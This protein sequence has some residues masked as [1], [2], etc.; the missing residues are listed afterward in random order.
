MRDFGSQSQSLIPRF[1][2]KQTCTIDSELHE[3][4]EERDKEFSWLKKLLRFDKGKSSIGCTLFILFL[5]HRAWLEWAL[6]VVLSI[7]MVSCLVA[8]LLAVQKRR[9][10]DSSGAETNCSRIKSVEFH[11][12]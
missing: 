6:G 12:T 7:V 3:A 10:D 8:T 2:T 9:S 5:Y 1:D 11:S 4:G